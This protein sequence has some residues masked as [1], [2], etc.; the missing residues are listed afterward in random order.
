M[1]TGSSLGPQTG[2]PRVDDALRSVDDL[3]ETPVDEHAERLSAAH[4]T[5]QEVLRTPTDGPSAPVPT[6]APR[7]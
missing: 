3:D 6:P 5:L 7:P 1:S 4:A 2:D